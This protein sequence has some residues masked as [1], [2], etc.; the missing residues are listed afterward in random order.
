MIFGY[1]PFTRVSRTKYAFAWCYQVAITATNNNVDYY[2]VANTKP[3]DVATVS[4]VGNDG[5]IVTSH[6]PQSPVAFSRAICYSWLFH[7]LFTSLCLEIINI[8]VTAFQYFC[9]L[10]YYILNTVKVTYYLLFQ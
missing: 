2:L 10:I 8:T 5:L 9:Y 7:N 3:H 1:Y 4:V 6:G